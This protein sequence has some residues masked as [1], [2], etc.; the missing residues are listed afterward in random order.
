MGTV[1]FRTR[2]TGGGWGPWTAADDDTG[3]DRQSSRGRGD[4][5]LA[6]RQPRLDGRVRPDRVPHSRH[7]SRGCAPTTSGAR[8]SRPA[9]RTPA[10]AAQPEIVS[11]FGWQANEKIVRAK[12]QIAASIKVAIVHHTV[13]ANSYTRAQAPALVRGI[14]TYHV[15]GNGWNDIGYNFVIDRFGTVY[16]GRGGGIDKNVIG[17]HSLGF[18]TGSVGVSLLGTYSR[19]APTQ[20][21]QDALVKLLAWR[22]D[23]AHLDPLSFQR[24]TS[25]GNSR[26]RAGSPVNLR[27]IS[28]HRDTYFTDCPG[29]NL[30]GKLPAIAAAVAK[31]GLP[32]IY[33]PVAAS[34][35]PEA[36]QLHRPPVERPALDGDRQRRVRRGRR[37]RLG[38]R[39]EGRLDV[40]RRH[41]G[42]RALSLDDRG[43]GRA[44]GD[45]DDRQGNPGRAPDRSGRLALG[46]DRRRD[47]DPR[48][49]LAWSAVDG[50]RAGAG[51]DR[52]PGH[53]RS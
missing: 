20:A 31:T 5:C 1:E 46:A 32:K 11:R 50:A 17:A 39:R 49:L 35:P 37:H 18:N 7:A 38:Q 42:P 51:R 34:T 33:E 19:A 13:N 30:Y 26:F 9:A 44:G 15:K 28:G 43:A 2:R 4:A 45:R 10:S 41:Q 47:R 12:P 14:E 16:E 21:Q 53:W 23:V 27:A 8:V 22:L 52:L 36:V 48:H 29:A 40:E 24:V 25:L 3:P 6:G